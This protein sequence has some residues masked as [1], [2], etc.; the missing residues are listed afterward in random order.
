M[1]FCFAAERCVEAGQVKGGSCSFYTFPPTD[2]SH[3]G[4]SALEQTLPEE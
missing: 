1:L 3:F 2:S 4:L